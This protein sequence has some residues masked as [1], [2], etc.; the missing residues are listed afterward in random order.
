[1]RG[2]VCN[3]SAL[4]PAVAPPTALAVLGKVSKYDT[5]SELVPF[6]VAVLGAV[7][8]P[9]AWSPAVAPP[10]PVAVLSFPYLNDA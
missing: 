9:I 1:M 5:L 4:S 8:S 10:S 7:C 2:A 6:P 3:P